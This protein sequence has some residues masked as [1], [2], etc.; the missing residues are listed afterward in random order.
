MLKLLNYLKSISGQLYV[1]FRIWRKVSNCWN[2]IDK[3]VE[4][5][6]RFS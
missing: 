2:F 5:R 6:I 1:D 3:T 4:N